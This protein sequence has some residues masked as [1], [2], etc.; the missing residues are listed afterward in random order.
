MV[1]CREQRGKCGRDLVASMNV[2]NKR[3]RRQALDSLA[4][5]RAQGQSARAVAKRISVILGNAMNAWK[6]VAVARG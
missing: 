5:A 3:E 2:S 6:R 1:P 4:E